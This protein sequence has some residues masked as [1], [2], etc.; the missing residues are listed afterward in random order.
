MNFQSKWGLTIR[1]RSYQRRQ[2]LSSDSWP[3]KVNAEKKVLRKPNRIDRRRKAAMPANSK[4][5]S[6]LRFKHDKL[7]CPK[8]WTNFMSHCRWPSIQRR[9]PNRA[10]Q[11]F[12]PRNP[13]L[14]SFQWETSS[15]HDL[16]NDEGLPSNRHNLHTCFHRHKHASNEWIP[17]S[18]KD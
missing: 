6:V 4:R 5:S 17:I 11:D 14:P 8:P 3:K 10:D 1:A 15:Y 13:N 7:S 18:R 12:Q 16:R 2:I 9:S